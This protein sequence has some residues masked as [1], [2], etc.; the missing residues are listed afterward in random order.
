MSL[1]FFGHTVQSSKR[2][3][4]ASEPESKLLRPAPQRTLCGVAAGDKEERDRAILA[5]ATG[6]ALRR[7]P[8]PRLCHWIVARRM[9]QFDCL[10]LILRPHLR[11]PWACRVRLG[12]RTTFCFPDLEVMDKR[13]PT[14]IRDIGICKIIGHGFEICTWI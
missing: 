1:G 5:I 7:E 8:R 12:Q 6:P 3:R 2:P 4:Q 13:W 9:P 10:R 11:L 14:G